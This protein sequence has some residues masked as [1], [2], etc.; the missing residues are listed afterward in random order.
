MSTVVKERHIYTG[1]VF[2][3]KGKKKGA[4]IPP[5]GPQ[6]THLHMAENSINSIGRGGSFAPARC[7]QLLKT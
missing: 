3:A 5:C 4:K 2:L 6:I 1:R 7:M